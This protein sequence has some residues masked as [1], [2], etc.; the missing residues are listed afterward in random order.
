MKANPVFYRF[1]LRILQVLIL[2]IVFNL[3]V[4]KLAGHGI[5][6]FFAMVLTILVVDAIFARALML[7]G[8]KDKA[9]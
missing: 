6:I 4:V 1:F 5:L 3:I 8:R 2:A 9:L 7:I